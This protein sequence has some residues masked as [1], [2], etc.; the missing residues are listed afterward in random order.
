MGACRA[1]WLKLGDNNMTPEFIFGDLAA[2]YRFSSSDVAEKAILMFARIQECDW[3][4]K[5]QAPDSYDRLRKAN[6][7]A[8][9]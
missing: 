6:L 3:A 8:H 9:W 5:M 2:N 1:D 7:L 4:R